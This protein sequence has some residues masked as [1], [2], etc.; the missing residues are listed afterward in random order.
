MDV[1]QKLRLTQFYAL[2]ISRLGAFYSNVYGGTIRYR[3]LQYE[4]FQNATE[5]F[6]S[7]SSYEQNKIE[8]W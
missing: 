1:P 2:K 7:S 5:I 4:A 3:K 6:Y 8:Y